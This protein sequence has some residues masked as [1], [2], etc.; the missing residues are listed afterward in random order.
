[1][2]PVIERVIKEI[3]NNPAAEETVF[4][5][6]LKNAQALN[7]EAVVNALF[8]G[9]TT[10][11]A[12]N[13]AAR[14]RWASRQR[15][16]LAPRQFGGWVRFTLG[17]QQLV[18]RR[19]AWE[20]PRRRL[21]GG[22]GGSAA[23]WR[24]LRRRRV[25]AAAGSGDAVAFRRT[26]AA[27]PRRVSPDRSPSSPIRTPIRCWCARSRSN[28]EQVKPSST[29]LDR[30]VPQVL[31]KVLVA[32]VTHD[33]STDIGAEF[34]VLNLRRQRQ[35]PERRHQ[36][37]HCRSPAGGLVVQV[38][39][40][41]LHRHAPRAGDRRQARRAL[42]ALH[43]RSRQPAREHHG[44]PGSAVHHQHAHHR[45]RADDQHDRVQGRRHHA[46]RDR[47]TST[48]MAW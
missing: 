10:G 32:E 48:P 12:G 27:A 17:E 42:A 33:N 23:V 22:G 40:S 41:E 18:V 35:R 24:W 15:H 4:V 36:L 47:R 39:E 16:I 25:S 11:S 3:D 9:T 26:R 1:M 20:Q 6:R 7:V 28:Y 30:A 38:L 31:I 44:R 2:L 21:G 34:S 45:H 37:R 43:P 46:G 8:N 5:Y 13:V 29:E 14:T 19:W